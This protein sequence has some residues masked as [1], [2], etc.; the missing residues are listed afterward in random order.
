MADIPEW[1]LPLFQDM[2]TIKE[3]VLSLPCLTNCPRPKNGDLRKWAIIALAFG[4]GIS[5]GTGA[6]LKALG[7]V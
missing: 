6:V 3:R 1:A 4:A 7:I 5:G 2:A